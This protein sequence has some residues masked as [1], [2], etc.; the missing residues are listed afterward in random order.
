MVSATNHHD[1]CYLFALLAGVPEL[2]RDKIIS[3]YADHAYDRA[4][5]ERLRAEGIYPHL[6][7]RGTVHGS[8]LGHYCWLVERTA[9]WL[10]QFRR[11]RIRYE[12]HDDT[13]TC[14]APSFLRPPP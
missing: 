7:K 13:D 6:A 8:G 4:F 5:R 2:L 3:L 1:S 9:S 12:Q 14:T 10:H 11:L